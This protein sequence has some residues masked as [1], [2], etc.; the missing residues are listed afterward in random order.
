[1]IRAV[2]HAEISKVYR[3]NGRH[4]GAEHDEIAWNA[5]LPEMLAWLWAKE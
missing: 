4:E 5:R 3:A 1:M 2:G